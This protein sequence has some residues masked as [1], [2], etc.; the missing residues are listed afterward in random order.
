MRQHSFNYY[1]KQWL[2][3]AILVTVLILILI[4]IIWMVVSSLKKTEE[5]MAYPIKFFPKVPQW[6]NYVQV[7]TRTPF[8]QLA[9]RT[10]VLAFTAGVIGII[11]SAMGGYAF[12]RFD[13]KGNKI[14]FP[15][16][17]ALLI[18]PGIV[19][20]IPQF[21]VFTRLKL[22]NTYLP[23][24]LGALGASPYFIFMFRQFF[25]R[26]PQEIE[27]AAEIDGCNPLRTFWQIFLP[28]SLP[29]L[30]TAF[31]FSFSGIWGDYLTP[32]LYLND[33]KTLLA[34][35]MAK[36]FVDPKGNPLLNVQLAANL[37]FIIPLVVV[38]FLGQ[39][40]IMQGVVTSGLKG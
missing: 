5:M 11:T 1:L 33:E 35:K 2:S 17:I 30:A 19:T 37:I 27:E 38:F 34:V 36:A 13:V 6:T 3:Y 12:A 25:F 24:Y 7:F 15:F 18:V 39:K 22:V 29:V 28:N 21:I 32:I 16:I 14:F 8:F 4:P 23:W 26:F 9:G 40:Y 31:I 10:S 20:L